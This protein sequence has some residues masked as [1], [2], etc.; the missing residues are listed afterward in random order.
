[1][2]SKTTIQKI[3]Q[4]AEI[5]EVVGDF[6][7]LRRNGANYWA[8]C[9]FHGEKTPSF[10]VAP[11]KNIFYCFGCHKTGN[12]VTFVMELE[13][14][15]YPD[16]LQYLAKKYHIEIEETEATPEQTAI[17]NE[18]ESLLIGLE[19]A[20]KYYQQL[21]TQTDEGQSIGLSYFKERGFNQA[22]ID[23]FELGYSQDAWNN[24]ESEALRKGFSK[25]VLLKTGLVIQKEDGK[26][27]DRFRGRVMFPIHNL[28]GRVVGFGA[29]TLKKDDKPKYLNSPETAVYIKNEV[30]YGLYQ[31]KNAI[32]EQDV[33]LLVEGYADVIS[34]YQNG[35]QN[36]VASSGTALTENQIRLIRRF[37]ENVVV[38][39]D[40]DTAGIKAALR[41][42]DLLLA[43]GLNVKAVTLPP[44]DDP[45]S[46]VRK[47]GGGAF[48]DYLAKNAKDFITFKIEL[49]L[50]EANNDPLKKATVIRS[51]VESIALIPDR[52]KQSVFY[53]KCSD[54]LGITED[55]LKAEGTKTEKQPLPKT[56]PTQPPPTQV[57][58]PKVEK[59]LV[60]IQEHES[61]RLLVK[62]GEIEIAPATKLWQYFTKETADL[63]MN[64]NLYREILQA[65]LI[66][67]NNGRVELEM[68]LQKV[69]VTAQKLIQGLLQEKHEVS[70]NWTEKHDIKIATEKDDLPKTVFKNILRLKHRIVEQAIKD[71]QAKFN[72]NTS[73]KDLQEYQAYLQL[74]M[75]LAKEIGLVV[76]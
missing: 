11:A 73:E 25:D 61:I 8:C 38:L 4:V 9:P 12:A 70:A 67:A 49:L 26:S 28:S 16:A 59:S 24:L 36:V 63:P 65:Y 47:I 50:V 31:A 13:K 69:S 30:L 2:I 74:K 76:G 68:L 72:D 56:S 44:E 17:A 71:K 35:V 19:F 66:L 37:T 43:Q 55:V 40:G 7:S 46:L 57:E 51:I 33:C 27:Y 5:L 41:G 18:R 75:S 15:S 10:S 60:E 23:K 58:K 21:L 45:D 39:Y 29:R 52:I 48:K 3:T 20:K 54:L 53:Q 6:V 34:L 62:Y 42:I 14:C 22:T 1:M 64:S 32:R